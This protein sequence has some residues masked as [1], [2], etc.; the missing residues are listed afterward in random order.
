MELKNKVFVS[1]CFDL[2]HSGHVEFLKNASKFGDL[3]VCIGSDETIK[4]LKGNYPVNKQ[5]ERKFIIESLKY[6]K[7]CLI[8]SSSGVLDFKNEIELVNPNI[9]I[10]NEDGDSQLKFTF[11]KNKKIQ[12]KVLSRTPHKNLPKRSSSSLKNE[13]T[14]PYRIDLSGGWLDQP[15]V[16]EIHSGSVVTISIEPNHKFN[17][18][19][20]MATST[21]KKAIELWKTKLP[22]DDNEKLSKILFSYENPPG[23]KIITGSQDSIGIVYPGVNKLSYKNSY[24]PKNIDSILSEKQLRFIEN[25]LYLIPLKPRVSDYD[26]LKKTN[27]NK[28]N[29]KEL[30]MSSNNLWNSIIELNI[31]KFGSSLLKSFE[32]Q[33]KMFPS[34]INQDINSKIKQYKNK[35]LGYKLSG[36]GGGGYLILVCRKSISNSIRIKIRRKNII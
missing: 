34:M 22:I 15:Y 2:I 25:N 7:K 8:G 36:S 19:S 23:K 9:F 1:G 35:C 10:V 27:L 29:I 3:Y 6:V 16:N 20:G 30:A 12:Y 28:K 13:I 11:F 17:L 4:E 31:E 26:V 24:W 21:R 18:R 14:I 5:N 32:S 33:I